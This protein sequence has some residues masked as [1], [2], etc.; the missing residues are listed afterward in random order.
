M[1]DPILNL[2][3]GLI[4]LV[5]PLI[6]I[7]IK[8]FMIKNSVAKDKESTA[9]QLIAGNSRKNTIHNIL[10]IVLVTLCYVLYA[11]TIILITYAS[12]I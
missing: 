3:I 7:S 4:A 10:H 11:V 12:V 2:K 9:F 6:Y 1:Y 5:L 8:A